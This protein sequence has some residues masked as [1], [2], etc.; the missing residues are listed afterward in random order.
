MIAEEKKVEARQAEPP[1]FVR[2]LSALAGFL[3]MMALIW[4]VV[5]VVGTGQ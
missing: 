4:F 1:V 2:A 3:L 5:Y